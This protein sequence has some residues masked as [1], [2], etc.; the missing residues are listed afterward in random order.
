M[1]Q[2]TKNVRDAGFMVVDS[3]EVVFSAFIDVIEAAVSMPV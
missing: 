1:G 2:N 3:R